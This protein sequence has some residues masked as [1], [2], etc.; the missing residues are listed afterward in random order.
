MSSSTIVNQRFV[1]CAFKLMLKIISYPAEIDSQ[2]SET[3]SQSIIRIVFYLAIASVLD[4]GNDALRAEFFFF[5]G[6]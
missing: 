1:S 5:R 3:Q 6:R 2:S 4:G